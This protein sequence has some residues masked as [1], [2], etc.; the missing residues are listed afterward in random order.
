MPAQ[1]RPAALRDP[2][3]RVLDY[4]RLAVTDRCNLRCRYCMPADGIALVDHDDVL[5]FEEMERL[6]RLLVTRGVRKIRITGGEPLVRRGVVDFMARLGALPGSPEILLTTNGVL[7]RGRLDDL[8]L[9]GVRRINLSLD[10]LDPATFET[11]ARRDVLADVLPL[12]DE[13]PAAGLGLKVN[14][15]VLPGVNDHELPDFVELTR[16]RDLTVRFIEPM[17]FDGT[18]LLAGR[19]IDGDGILEILNSRVH[20]ERAVGDPRGVDEIYAVEGWRGRVGLIRGHSRTFCATCSRLRID[21]QGALRT[22]LYGAARVS[23]RT[24]IRT[25]A[26]DDE[27]IAAIGAA[28]AGR[29]DDG[30]AAARD[31]D[32]PA[33]QSM[34]S[35]GG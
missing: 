15:V 29:F 24:L 21:A 19:S 30:H 4:L 28:V 1:T 6:C 22:C 11:I 16:D 2:Q 33:H 20:L 34:A 17:P 10:S 8:R 5:R 9:A 3:G 27:L 7:L 18:G 35:I 32:D 23:L 25:G 31:R 14:V 13:I 12:L 26:T